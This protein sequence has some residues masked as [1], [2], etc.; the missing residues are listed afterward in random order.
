MDSRVEKIA[1]I[2][3]DCPN[4][5]RSRK[6]CE[7]HYRRWHKWGDPLVLKPPHKVTRYRPVLIRFWEK[8]DK[9]GPNGCWL[10]LGGIGSRTNGGYGV[11]WNGE[12]NT[13]AHRFSYELHKGP[14][15]DDMTVDHLCYNPPCVNPDHLR[16]LTNSENSKGRR[17]VLLEVCKAG[18]HKRSENWYT[19]PTG[20]GSCCGA[21]AMD[22]QRARRARL[23]GEVA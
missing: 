3:D 13:G 6:M 15:P 18:L 7:K 16:L 22:R 23:P 1:C 12:N 17:I 14:I 9:N 19:A 11:F 21:C 4:P 20:R 8:V 10:W 2:I 5:A